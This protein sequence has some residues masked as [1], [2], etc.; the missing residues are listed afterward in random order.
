M[1]KED[2]CR[3]GAER[4]QNG[5]VDAAIAD[6]TEAARLD[7]NDGWVYYT[8]GA[9]YLLNKRDHDK[10]IEDLN[11]AI[12]LNRNDAEAYHYRGMAYQIGRNDYDRSIVDFTEA[13]RL[14]PDKDKTYYYRG[15]AYFIK[16]DYDK[17]N[18]DFWKVMEM[19]HNPGAI[20]ELRRESSQFPS[21]DVAFFL[22]STLAKIMQ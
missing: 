16:K 1:N 10:A 9:I 3:R 15:M 14:N 17:A 4:Y 12:R 21:K 20:E 5:E 2:Y 22:Q 18:V 6:F 19:T 13:I 11:E 7:P 8:R